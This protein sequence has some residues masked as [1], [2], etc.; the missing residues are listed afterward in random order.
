MIGKELFRDSLRPLLRRRGVTAIVI[1]T[2]AL[3]VG[4]NAGIF[5]VFH[6]IL[7]QE[8]SVPDPDE[9]VVLDSPGPRDGSVTTD[10]TG[11][12]RQIFSY[13]LYEDLRSA[14]DT[15]A[16][17]GA[18]RSIGINLGA[19]G[20]TTSGRGLLVSGNYFDVLSLRPV[21]GR[22]FSGDELESAG[23][24]RVVVLTYGLWQ[25]RFGGD[26]AMIGESIM[27]NGQSLEII[28]VAPPEFGGLNRFWPADAFL[29]LTL[30]DDLTPWG[31]W[32]LEDRRS[33]WLYLF[34]RLSD[35]VP[36]E[37]ASAGLAP[38]FRNLIRE[39]EAPLQ[40]GR[41]ETWM[42][43]FMDRELQLLP[44]TQGQ[45]NTLESVRTPMILLLCVAAL[46]L[47]VACVNITNLLLALGA[48]ERGE[49]ALR[50]ALGAGRRHIVGQRVAVLMLLALAG[51]LVS[52]P[53]AMAT[54]R[55]VIHLLP[56]SDAAILSA[57]L[58]WRIVSAGLATSIV[59]LVIAGTAPTLQAI[60]N[61]PIE[62]IRDQAARSGLSRAA[63]RFRSML[64][65]GQIALALALLVVS[66]LFIRSLANINSVELGLEPD[67]VMSFSISPVRNGYST[68]QARDL[69]RTIE[70]RLSGLPAVSA[71]SVSMVPILSDSNWGSNLSV[72]G[73]DDSPDTN[74]NAGYN[75]VGPDFFEALSIPLLRG[76]IFD[77]SD[78]NGRPR[79]AIVNQAFLRKFE[80][81][82][83]GLGAR[84]AMGRESDVELDI[85][86]VGV[87]GDAAYSSVKESIPPQFFLSIYQTEN[88]GSASF[89]VRARQEPETL[90]P[91]IRALVAQLDPNLPVDDLF[92]LD[93][94]AGTT[95][96]VD[97]VIATL[98]IVFAVLATTLAAVG[99]FGVL[100]FA[101]A[102]RT[103]E[104]GLRAALGAAP[105]SLVRLMLT[106][107][108]RLAMFGG[109]VG[110]VLAW[111]LGNMARGL[112]YELSPFEPLVI[113]GAMAVL[114]CVVLLASWLP[115]RRAARIHPVQALRYE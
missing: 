42:Q 59:A 14:T 71:A 78:R 33:H 108:L 94:V 72:E 74:T 13:P 61:R 52:V 88:V 11:R 6:Q 54:L 32:S 85:E 102:Q 34:G 9:V 47:L 114:V 63:T 75:A 105:T 12:D 80:L 81:E 58:D 113:L 35:G 5:S 43:R 87:V 64:V 4:M 2:L 76:R 25:D 36:I 53:V 67:S 68:E 70:Q 49:T 104:I 22:F 89:Y 107:T 96:V 55:L 40:E 46:V 27:V 19:R 106:Q 69:F 82:Q 109:A 20:Q 79:V 84:M 100:S 51:T 24:P 111:L 45:S 15:L 103:G 29:P 93:T 44:G 17:M 31:I 97:R 8:L 3:G 60:S 30:V 95:V 83:S 90:V 115:A 91:E 86:I 26:P 57:A 41:S 18:F 7:L 110:L 112:L 1:L 16:G 73:F 62:A 23:A 10:G 56:A 101:L 37:R 92:T 28:G 98:S 66:G 77:E 39:V 50:Q 38:I 99:L 65:A 48:S 21:A